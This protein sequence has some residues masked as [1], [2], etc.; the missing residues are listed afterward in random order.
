MLGDHALEPK[1]GTLE[2]RLRERRGPGLEARGAG[3]ARL[4]HRMRQQRRTDA[5][6]RQRR[7]NVERVHFADAAMHRDA[8]EATRHAIVAFVD[9]GLGVQD[10]AG[11]ARAVFGRSCP[12]LHLRWRVDPWAERE[13]RVAVQR[14]QRLDVAGAGPAQA[15]WNRRRATALPAAMS[16]DSSARYNVFS[17]SAIVV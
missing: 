1:A 12:G 14:G 6:A 11:K 10:V 9:P 7:P 13:R 4:A 3:G 15:H 16:R 5:L 2:Q 8:A 17:S